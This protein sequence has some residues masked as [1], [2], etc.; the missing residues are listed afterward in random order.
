MGSPTAVTARLVSG[1]GAVRV[2]LTYAVAL[3]GV[4]LT[5]TALGRHAREVAVSRMST[6][7]HNLAHGRVATLV[8]S[9]FLDSGGAVVVWLPGLVCLLALGE[10]AWRG[11]GVLL[12]F[13]VGH[14][15]ATLIV[16]AGLVAAVETRWLPGSVAHASDVGISYGAVGVLGALTAAIPSHRRAAW[17]GWWIGA[18]VA[19]APAAGFTGVGH[20][21]A[22]LLGIC[23]SARLPAMTRWTAPRVA[24]LAVGAV[25]G[26]CVV[27]GPSVAAPVAALAGAVCAGLAGKAVTHS[28]W[29]SRTRAGAAR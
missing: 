18:A 2:T 8:G 11:R 4:S 9:A 19:A 13:V 1:A 7:L 15:G 14:V 25:F 23:L 12:A 28:R 29:R 3:A 26:F 17:A 22:L 24:L 5:L 20:I 6:N 27:A 16:A 10:L 21:V